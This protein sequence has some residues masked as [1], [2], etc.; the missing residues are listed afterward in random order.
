MSVKSIVIFHSTLESK[1]NNLNTF[2][3]R[4]FELGIWDTSILLIWLTGWL[5]SV[6]VTH[7]S[8]FPT[9]QMSSPEE[10]PQGKVRNSRLHYL[11][12]NFKLFVVGN[13][14]QTGFCSFVSIFYSPHVLRQRPPDCLSIAWA[15]TCLISIASKL[16]P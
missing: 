15:L 8:H 5:S 6:F 4:K 1:I 12:F 9:T 16:V 3:G 10:E 7:C 2:R 14:L 11:Q 13:V